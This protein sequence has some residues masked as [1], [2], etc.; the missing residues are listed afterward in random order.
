MTTLVKNNTGLQP[1]TA[2][3]GVAGTALA[4]RASHGF[5][6]V[7]APAVKQA[8]QLRRALVT[9]LLVLYPAMATA[10]VVIAALVFSG[11]RPIV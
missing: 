3:H 4:S 5:A 6:A 11:A 10:A 1:M 7:A 9:M 8:D 2:D